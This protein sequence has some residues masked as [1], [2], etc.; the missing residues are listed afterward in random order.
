VTSLLEWRWGPLF[1]IALLV[2]T[3]GG[4]WWYLRRRHWY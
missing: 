2:A 4:T 3:A 1:V